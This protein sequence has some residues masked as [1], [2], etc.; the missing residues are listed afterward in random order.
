MAQE[1]KVTLGMG[2]IATLVSALMIFVL[3]CLWNQHGRI[4]V[5]EAQQLGISEKLSKVDS[6]LDKMEPILWEVRQD[7]IRREVEAKKAKRLQD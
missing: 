2:V 6:K 4:T 3:G 7:Q 5:V 1:T